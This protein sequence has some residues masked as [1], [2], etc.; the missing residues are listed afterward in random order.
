MA[1]TEFGKIVRNAR[2]EARE[3]LESMAESLN[4]SPSFLNRIELGKAK[5]N[6]EWIEKIESFLWVYLDSEKLQIAA[7]LSNGYISLDGMSH[8][9]KHILTRLAYSSGLG[10]ESF[11]RI[12]KELNHE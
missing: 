10:H 4:V 6:K 2:A 11:D 3:T 1:V 9:R 7:D 5:I 12:L 8:T